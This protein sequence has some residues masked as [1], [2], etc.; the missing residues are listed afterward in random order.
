MIQLLG[1]SFRRLLPTPEQILTLQVTLVAFLIHEE[2]A[3]TTLYIK[4]GWKPKEH[5]W[6]V[7]FLIY[8]IGIGKFQTFCS[9]GKLRISLFCP[10][11]KI[12]AFSTF[13]HYLKTQRIL[14]HIQRLSCCIHAVL[15]EEGSSWTG[16]GSRQPQ[17]KQLIPSP[18]LK[19]HV[20]HFG[21]CPCIALLYLG[22]LGLKEAGNFVLQV[23]D[24]SAD[25]R[26]EVAEKPAG[27]D[28]SE[29]ISKLKVC[30]K[31]DIAHRWERVRL[32]EAGK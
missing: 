13:S 20:Q 8:K 24:C 29:I 26:A 27:A 1:R 12:M 25:H 17:W 11:S 15:S 6:T 10:G 28:G 30:G 5:I 31:H 32:R 2:A 22:M 9:L 21:L 4:T 23:N 19:P 7:C 3:D 14:S 16:T 18:G